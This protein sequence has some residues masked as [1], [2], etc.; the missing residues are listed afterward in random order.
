VASCWGGRYGSTPNP[1]GFSVAAAAGRPPSLHLIR[2]CP[3]QSHRIPRIEKAPPS[4]TGLSGYAYS[5]LSEGSPVPRHLRRKANSRRGVTAEDCAKN[6]ADTNDRAP[7][8]S[9]AL[10]CRWRGQ[11]PSGR[12]R[13]IWATCSTVFMARTSRRPSGFPQPS[14]ANVI[15]RF[16]LDVGGANDLGLQLPTEL[17]IK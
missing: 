9:A 7:A 10:C 2:A 1:H 12:A 14:L 15:L 4:R 5:L 3:H 13:F 8:L 16:S 11:P 6:A 17:A